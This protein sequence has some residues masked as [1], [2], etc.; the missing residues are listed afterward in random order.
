MQGMQMVMGP[1]GPMMA[2]PMPQGMMPAGAMAA[3]QLTQMLV[4]A[5]RGGRS[6]NVFFKTRICNKWRS[7]ACPY[8]DKCTYAHGEHE[9]R[10]VPPEVVAQLEAQQKMQDPQQQRQGGGEGQQQP[11]E[12]GPHSGGGPAPAMYGGSPGPAGGMGHQSFYKTRLCI[13]YMQTGFCHKA[14]G[15]TFAHGYED[16]RQPGTP[17]SPGAMAMQEPMSPTRMAMGMAHGGVAMMPAAQAAMMGMQMGMAPAGAP[18][19]GAR[20]RGMPLPMPMPGS[21][22]YPPGQQQQQQP[23]QQQRS[24]RSGGGNARDDPA[25]AARR[26]ATAMCR[27]AGV[28]P[29]GGEEA[30]PGSMQAAMG[31]VRSGAAF[32]ESA[33]ADSVADYVE[34]QAPAGQGQGQGQPGPSAPDEDAG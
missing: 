16:L 25:S 30:R 33:Y 14:A 15:C 6:S 28:G 9:L 34:G 2:G 21:G 7:G 32:K 11:G 10:Y 22:R 29:V 13:K 20:P 26:R 31:E 1:M 8:G 23:P 3:P 12:E 5:A 18:V 17:L 4:E 19:A 24:P 27:I